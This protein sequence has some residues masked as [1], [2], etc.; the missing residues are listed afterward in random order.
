MSAILKDVLKRLFQKLIS[1]YSGVNYTSGL[2]I[3][4]ISPDHG[5][6]YDMIDN[7][8]QSSKEEVYIE[9]EVAVKKDI[10]IIVTNGS[11]SFKIDGYRKN[12]AN[13]IQLKSIGP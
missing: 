11:I 9:E 4:R 13:K 7:K 10:P 12:E 5:T 3:I 2:N 8:Q 1:N 6:A